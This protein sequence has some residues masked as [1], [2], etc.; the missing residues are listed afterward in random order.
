M[1]PFR[2]REEAGNKLAERLSALSLESPALLAVPRGG[3]LVAAPVARKLRV[4]LGVVPIRRL[5]I[6]WAKDL[7]IGYTT[8][9]GELHL[10]HPLVGQ[11]RVSRQQIY[12][13]AKKEQKA[14]QQE[15]DT[16]GAVP[17]SSLALQTVVI[18]DEGLHS[19]WTMFSAVETVK[20]RGAK[21]II[22][23]TPVSHFRAQ[24]FV[25]RHCDQFISLITEDAPLFHIADYYQQFPEVSDDQIRSALA[26]SA[27]S[28]ETAA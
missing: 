7:E 5:P 10:N 27:P 8:D 25:G 19:G 12:Q 14:L 24:R 6:Q 2:N 21:K 4:P 17:P 13:I 23:A 18:V 28:S 11:L 20:K 15:L 1:D 9:T 16:W 3:V 22:V 26:P